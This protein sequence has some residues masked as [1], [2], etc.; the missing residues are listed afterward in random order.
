MVKPEAKW[1]TKAKWFSQ[2]CSGL[3]MTEIIVSRGDS[4]TNYAEMVP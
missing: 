3:T 2:Q 1:F 4:S